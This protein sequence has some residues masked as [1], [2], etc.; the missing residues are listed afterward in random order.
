M[1]AE[2]TTR[3]PT[4]AA[5]AASLP[6]DADDR[7]ALHAWTWTVWV[8]CAALCIQLAPNPVYVA[9]VIA[10]SLAVVAA[11]A[12]DR[13]LR[14][15]VPVVI[16]VAAV[17]VGVRVVLMALTT[18]GTGT[19]L[20]RVPSLRLPT[21]LGGFTVGGTIESQVIMQAAVEG[22]VVV[23]LVAAFAAFN[24]CVSH[25][26]LVQRL[27]RA[28][29]ELGLVL[30]VSLVF[31]PATIG[32]V[33][34]VRETDRAR[35]GGVPVRRRRLRRTVVPVLET[36]MERA[37]ALAETMDARGFGRHGADTRHLV[38]AIASMAG[39]VCCVGALVA[40]VAQARTA[41]AMLGVA[42]LVAVAIA[43]AASSRAVRR[44]RYRSR[45]PRRVDVIVMCV[46]CCAPLAL[47]TARLLG[48]PTL[49]WPPAPGPAT[50]ATADAIGWLALVAL[51]P[52]AAPVVAGGRTTGAGSRG[53]GSRGAADRSG[54][55][56]Q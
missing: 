7:S 29:H 28:F 39:L 12:G 35:T 10:T 21:V 1:L 6:V 45:S 22:F 15:M 9:A 20:F 32:A 31:L 40:L 34:T 11:Q 42:S 13:P 54:E 49:V 2:R 17:F 53:A 38:T 47:A 41:A 46:V 33:R 43:V 50:S 37:L 25:R 56:R 52:L 24:A 19:E 3:R 44:V 55:E 5:A 48:D 16:G 14:R 27:P 8:A 26:E 23:G 18:H 51:V 36:G 4:G 30:V